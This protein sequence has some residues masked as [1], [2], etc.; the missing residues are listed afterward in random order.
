MDN[1][2]KVE[3]H[4]HLEGAASPSFVKD[5]ATK[6]NLDLTQIFSSDGNYNFKN[7]QHF[8]SVYELATTVLQL[9]EDFYNLTM[10]VL[11][12]C[13]A[14]NVLYVETFV[15]P[16]FCG[17]NDLCA[18]KDFLAAIQ[19]ASEESERQYNIISRGIVTV[20]RHLGPEV[21]K[22]TAK[23][24]VSTAGEWI[25]G[26]GMAGDES[27]GQQNDYRYSF[28][29]ARGAGL[30]LT[31]HAGEWCGSGSVADA[32]ND[33][34]VQRVGH[35]VQAINDQD[36][37]KLLVD[38]EIVLETC[39]GSNVFLG[40]YPNLAMHPIN[41]LRALGVKVTVSTD[42]PPFFR[43]SMNQEYKNLVQVFD[44]TKNDVIE[45]NKVALEAAF[46]DD[47]TKAALLTKLELNTLNYE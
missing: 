1:L 16:Q 46:C 39:P 24:A 28:D 27:V 31:S 18:W 22:E 43:T 20:I 37:V 13:A 14:N 11:K 21:A 6:K 19:A 44:W 8:L 30:K 33:L 42:D 47:K 29:M 41:T 26:F 12:E 15:S 3:L 7:F 25:V 5:L 36:V 38:K 4:L 23:C 10:N 17:G 32:V 40:V 34:E 9:P 45:L 35:G 2:P